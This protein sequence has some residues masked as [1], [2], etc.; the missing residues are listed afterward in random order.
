MEKWER[1]ARNLKAKG[2]KRDF[3]CLWGGY[4]P[5]DDDLDQILADHKVWLLDSSFPEK[6]KPESDPPHCLEQASLFKRELERANLRF[7]NLRK[8]NLTY[9]DFTQAD[10]YQSEL[11]EAIFFRTDLQKANLTKADLRGAKLEWSDLTEARLFNSKLESTSLKGTVLDQALIVNITYN[12]KI[13][14]QAVRANNCQGDAQFRRFLQDQDYLESFQ[15]KYPNWYKLWWLFA[16]CGRS[17]T[18]WALWSLF[19]ALAFAAIYFFGFGPD[20]FDFPTQLG[21]KYWTLCYY[22][23]VTFT[24]LGFGDIT[25]LN[26]WAAFWITIEVIFGYIMLGGLISIFANKL[27]R[28]S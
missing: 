2:K 11:G 10:L 22:S 25:P 16:D 21:W 14:C 24:T 19:F 13:K 20:A 28:R 17:I 15:E 26:P 23:I 3:T 8:A 4:R 5:T 1:R 12:T 9:A 6:T 18:R 27:A 7:I